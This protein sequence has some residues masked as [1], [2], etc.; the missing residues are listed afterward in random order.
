MVRTGS[1]QN[2][3]SGKNGDIHGSRWLSR[4]NRDGGCGAARR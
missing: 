4:V 2:I 3:A 1:S